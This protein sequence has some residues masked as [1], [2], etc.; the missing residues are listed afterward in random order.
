[1]E[2]LLKYGIELAAAAVAAVVAIKVA[3]AR[4][5]ERLT[6][7]RNE[8]ADLEAEHNKIEGKI[9]KLI[10]LQTQTSIQ[11]ARLAAIIER[12]SHIHP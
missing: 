5:D 4:I 10:E 9:D 1:M 2:D 7:L 11:I 12:P 3:V 6:S 8:I